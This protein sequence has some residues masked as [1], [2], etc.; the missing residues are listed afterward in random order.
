MLTILWNQISGIDD[1]GPA[2]DFTVKREVV[3]KEEVDPLLERLLRE[4]CDL[5]EIVV[6]SV[7]KGHIYG[8]TE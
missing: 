4:D 7:L 6:A 1:A 3:K 8:K 5:L 2:P